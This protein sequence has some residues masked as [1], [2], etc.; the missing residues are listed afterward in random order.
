MREAGTPSGGERAGDSIGTGL[1]LT[2]SDY[3][4]AGGR[5]QDVERPRLG[6][7]GEPSPHRGFARAIDHKVEVVLAA[8][9]GLAM[10]LDPVLRSLGG[11]EQRQQERSHPGVRRGAAV[12]GVAVFGDE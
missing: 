3:L 7:R 12:G 8:G 2:A 10:D 5:R 4:F 11:R 9:D 1:A 6:E